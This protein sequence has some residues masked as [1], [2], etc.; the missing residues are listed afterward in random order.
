M[1]K[2]SHDIQV[3]AKKL[4]QDINEYNYQYYVLDNPTVPDAE[5]DRLLRKL[6]ELETLH[7]ELI[8]PDSPTQRV[9]AKP[10]KFFP[11]VVHEAPM[12]S[13]D[14]AFTDEEVFN[15]D[16]RIKERLETEEDIEYCAEPKLDGIAV[17][18]LYKDGVFVQGS[19]RGDGY[20][21]ED[22][23][24]NL[25]TIPSVPLT[26]R[27]HD[28]PK[29][30]EVRGEIYLP[31]K[32]FEKL[33]EQA[34]KLGEK[35]FV[36]PR[37]AAAGSLRQLDPKITAQR[38][39]ELFCYGIG[40]TNPELNVTKHSQVLEQL[41]NWGLRVSSE[42]HIQ[43]NIQDCLKFYKKIEKKRQALPFEID[44][45]VYKVNNLALQHE[46]GFV[47]RAPR[48]AV[49]HKFPAQE[50]MTQVNDVEFQV[51]RT[52]T[53]TPIARLQP[54][55]VGGAT[56]SNATLHN[57]DEVQRKDVRIGD[58]VIVRRAG[59]VIPEL[60]SV[61]K[62]KRPKNTKKV[63]LPS[64]CPVCGSEV[65]R[66]EGEAAARCSAG[67]YCPAQRKESIRHFASRRA[68]NIEGLGDKLVEQLVDLGLIKNVADLYF[69]KSGEIAD[70]ER[71]GEKSADNLITAIEKSK[72]TTL[73]KFIYSLG[74][75]EVGEATAQTLAQHFS[76]LEKII[77]AD[78]ESLQQVSDVGPVVA[79]HLLDFFHQDHNLEIIKKLQS[80]GVHWPDLKPPAKH[81]Q[82]L[83]GKTVVLTG[84]L[85]SMTRDEAKMRLQELGAKVSGSVSKNTSFVVVGENAGSKLTDAERLGI[86]IL[87][88]KSFLT[89]LANK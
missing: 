24:L 33:N 23:T 38:P 21:G 61:I 52:G 68:M 76:R 26:L 48:F 73:A 1:T 64:N 47:S 4:R 14:N 46:L 62:E 45:V 10:A 50:E 36:N 32:G 44:G 66:E 2:I 8:T 53:L 86:E 84:T 16:R 39:L 42:V 83:A 85:S 35:L 59:D 78:E 56:V 79:K 13:L 27:G 11:E 9:G 87:D 41:K 72:K 81:Q 51:G 69:L 88:E 30:L 54:I 15:F 17:N 5:Y 77:A 67:L 6:I 20:V 29:L 3:Q 75:R 34:A 70:L 43:K 57:M 40:K 60:V 58:Y 25:R 80:A 31:K 12:L 19:T 28:H 37:N 74:I 49:A 89:F 7:P 22:I 65:I 18:L 82:V 63:I 55:F 71:M